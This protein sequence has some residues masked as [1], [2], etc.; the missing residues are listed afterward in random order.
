[1]NCISQLE[2]YL[3]QG[4]VFLLLFL[5]RAPWT[6]E[7]RSVR[8]RCSAAGTIPFSQPV[9]LLSDSFCEIRN[10]MR[11]SHRQSFTVLAG[12]PVARPRFGHAHLNAAMS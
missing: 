2:C 10:S 6:S 1:V 8:R 4:Q 3:L 11:G 12:F 9:R 5:S 7:R